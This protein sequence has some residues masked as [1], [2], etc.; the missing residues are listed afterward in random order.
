M[1]RRGLTMI[2]MLLALALLGAVMAA[3]L[4]WLSM[5]AGLVARVAEPVR[6]EALVTAVFALIHDDLV[7][8]DL[9][10]RAPHEPDRVRAQ[11]HM[12]EIDSRTGWSHRYRFD[13]STHRLDRQEVSPVS[14]RTRPLLGEVAQFGAVVDE[15]RRWIDI[16]LAL[17]PARGDPIGS[18]RDPNAVPERWERR[19]NLP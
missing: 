16:T 5:S 12:L 14:N 10:V 17:R 7:S 6:R 1:T 11:E 13:P 18:A 15:R 3:A 19:F 4:G 2:E 9:W 8:G